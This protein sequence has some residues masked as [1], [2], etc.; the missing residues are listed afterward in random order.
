MQI[1][2]A[3][4]KLVKHDT[5]LFLAGSI[6]M[7]AAENWQQSIEKL[8][9]NEEGVIYNP[10]RDDWDSSWEQKYTNKQF[11]EQVEW[12]LEAMDTAKTVAMYFDGK[13]K[14]PITLLELGLHAADGKLVVYC[15]QSFWRQGNVEVVCRKYDIPLFDS[16]KEWVS[17]LKE[18]VL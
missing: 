12:E 13:T 1:I 14:S 16:K 5:S 9:R 15:P 7:G 2:K 17:K 11:R 3:P 18:T 8:F 6:E 10:R 4:N